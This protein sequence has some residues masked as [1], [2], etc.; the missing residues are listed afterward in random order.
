M[1]PIFICSLLLSVI[2]NW[3]LLSSMAAIPIPS[4]QSCPSVPGSPAVQ[5]IPGMPCCP[6][7]PCGHTAH[8]APVAP[9]GHCGHTIAPAL[10]TDPSHR[11]TKR[12]PPDT[13]TLEIVL[14]VPEVKLK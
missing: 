4:F 7:I 9:C 12:F 14:L 1:D 10:N 2:I 5:G 11:P 8:C 6:A 13:V 3:S